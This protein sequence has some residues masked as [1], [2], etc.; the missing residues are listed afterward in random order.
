MIS[1]TTITPGRCFA[2]LAGLLVTLPLNLLHAQQQFPSTLRD[3]TITENR[4]QIVDINGALRPDVAYTATGGGATIYFRENGPSFVFTSA[5]N[6]LEPAATVQRIDLDLLGANRQPEIVVEEQ[7]PGTASY[8]LSHLPDGIH[9]LRSWRRLVYRNIYPNIDLVFGS[10]SAGIQAGF[11][12][13]PGGRISDIAYRF[14]GGGEVGQ[15]RTGA[16]AAITVHPEGD[17]GNVTIHLGVDAIATQKVRSEHG[18]Q[19]VPL[20]GQVESAPVLSKVADDPTV[21]WAT[22][23]GGSATDYGSN[24]TADIDGNVI[25]TGHTGSTDF[26]A[27]PGSYQA[28]SGGPYDAFI[29]KFNATGGRRWVTYYGGTGSDLGFGI[30]VDRSNNILIGGEAGMGFPVTQGVAQTTFG[31]GA[32]DGFVLK[33]DANGVRVWATYYGGT[34][35]D[36]GLGF[37]V[38]QEGNALLCGRTSSADFPTSTGAFQ[39]TIGGG[40]NLYDAF[41]V[42]LNSSGVR[43]WATFYGGSDNDYSNS[44]ASDSTGNIVLTG[45]TFSDNFPVS[46]GA[47]QTER[48]DSAGTFKATDGFIVRF[49]SDGSRKWATYFGGMGDDFIFDVAVDRSGDAVVVGSTGSTDLPVTPGALQGKY[50][51]SSDAFVARFSL[52]GTRQWATYYGGTRKEDGRGV[53]IGSNGGIVVAGSTESTDLPVSPTAVQGTNGGKVDLFILQISSVGDKVWSSYFGGPGED[54]LGIGGVGIDTTGNLLLTGNTDGNAFPV[55]SES[56]QFIY[57]GGDVDALL[58]KLAIAIANP[59]GPVPIVNEESGSIALEALTPNP[60]RE[61]ARLQFR[62]AMP[63]TVSITVYASDGSRVLTPVDSRLFDAGEHIL[64][65]DLQGLASGNYIIEL[66]SPRGRGVASLIVTR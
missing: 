7:I 66:R 35:N 29:A 39:S 57:G 55:T 62:L 45:T 60:T 54:R 31:G 50:A 34:G 63:Q 9:G 15:D 52:G 17:A 53:A 8:Y 19:I 49:G 38:D 22:Y 5:E 3:V 36:Q 14:V 40:G 33:L 30:A 28:T 18:E 44:V 56:F 20:F 61:S 4:G 59:P 21:A 6:T 43:Q 48:A 24:V 12:V 1:C 58:V 51:D 26:P 47:Y 42:K 13:H 37:T 32:V 65:V 2:V 64:P 46:A 25:V 11:A 27:S 23:M 41:L 10:A 16:L